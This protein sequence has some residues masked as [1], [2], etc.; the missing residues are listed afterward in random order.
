MTEN[1]ADA[2]SRALVKEL[3][4][5]GR[6]KRRC[7]QPEAGFVFLRRVAVSSRTHGRLLSTACGRVG[8]SRRRVSPPRHALNH[9]WCGY[10]NRRQRRRNW[11]RGRCQSA[12]EPHTCYRRASGRGRRRAGGRTG[13][14]AAKRG[15]VWT[16]FRSGPLDAQPLHDWGNDRQQRLREKS[17]PGLW[18]H[19]RQRHL[20]RRADRHWGTTYPRTSRTR[21]IAAQF[22][23]RGSYRLAVFDRRA[24]RDDPHGVRAVFAAVLRVFARASAAGASL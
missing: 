14:P 16:S 2:A 3:A 12:L 8:R 22:P 7:Q 13:P 21:T 15:T 10:V 17:S 11:S 19:L 1:Q 5:S 18:A 6:G 20:S 23:E 9:A 4:R 24:S